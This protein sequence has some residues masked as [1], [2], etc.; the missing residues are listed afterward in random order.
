MQIT[1]LKYQTT[2]FGGF[3]YPPTPETMLR[4]LPRVGPLGYMPQVQNV[5]EGVTGEIGPRVTLIKDSSQVFLHNS[6]IDVL[7]WL[8]EME[9]E[10]FISSTVNLLTLLEGGLLFSSRVALVT[11]SMLEELG[12]H[13]I[14][15][16]RRILVPRS[17][18][19][20]LEWTSRWVERK[21]VG[22]ETYH[23]SFEALRAAGM[24]M[25]TNGVSRTLTGIK[26]QHDV[27]TSPSNASPRFTQDNMVDSLIEISKILTQQNASI[28]Q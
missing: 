12:E 26:V 11:E 4:I 22:G 6:R 16:Y 27:S 3:N 18:E 24:I 20:T 25:T 17:D 23:I 7:T 15:N 10:E 5:T 21:T 14:E 2:I 9:L 13:E 8:P 28:L 1:K 19:S